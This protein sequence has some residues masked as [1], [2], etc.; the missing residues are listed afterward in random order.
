[1]DAVQQG[2]H[3]GLAQESLPRQ[4]AGPHGLR[5]A[6][7]AGVLAAG[8]VSADVPVAQDEF[9]VDARHGCRDGIAADRDLPRG[10]REEADA[11]LAA[12]RQPHR[13]IP[14]ALTRAG[15]DLADIGAVRVQDA[16]DDGSALHVARER[17][18]VGPN[19]ARAVHAQRQLRLAA[20]A[21]PA[22]PL[23]PYSPKALAKA[24]TEAAT[25]LGLH[26]HGRRAERTRDHTEGALR[27][28]GVT[29]ETL[30]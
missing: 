19:T 27:A 21:G 29:V 26:V 13:A 18:A 7:G 30:P 9:V 5:D 8:P 3:D 4:S 25:D 28:L 10:P 24:L 12:Y 15:R 23:L 17:I 22:D 16:A 6:E 1:M 2:G 11:A 14:V 20:G